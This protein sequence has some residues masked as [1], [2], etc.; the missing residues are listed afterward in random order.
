MTMTDHAWPPPDWTGELPAIT[1]AEVFAIV[2]DARDVTILDGTATI[3]K[4]CHFCSRP[5]V[6]T[7]PV[8]GLLLYLVGAH[9]QDAFPGLPAAERETLISGS[10]S[11]C[12][13]RACA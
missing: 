6:V 9:A 1:D 11:E 8:E 10:H 7:V 13:D 12:F 2:L 3:T 5:S 4:T